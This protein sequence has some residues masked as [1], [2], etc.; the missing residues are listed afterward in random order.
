MSGLVFLA[1]LCA[2]VLHA[3]WNAFVKGSSDKSLSMGAVA[4]GHLPLALAILP[5]VSLPHAASLPYLATGIALHFA[6]QL[7]L[8]RSY[9]IGDLTQVYPIA[10]GSAPLLVAAIS[11]LVLGEELSRTEFLGIAVIGLGIISLSI[12]RRAD[13]HA[14]GRAAV[15]AT[16]TGMFI[17]AYSI[18]DGHGARLA[19]SALGFYCWVAIGNAAMMGTYLGLFRRE[20]LRALPKRGRRLFFVGGSMS[21]L[22]YGL[23]IWSFTQAPIALVTALRETSVVF[24]L[25]IGVFV[26]RERLSLLKLVSTMMTLFGAVLLR[27]AR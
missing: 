21:F 19:G 8:I 6:Y 11:F 14:N 2:A 20:S 3:V 5:F 12:V 23:V 15:L 10:R 13:G 1:V 25:L 24:A 9:E 16:I 26:L 18:V 22:A 27:W 17:A 4:L 7:F